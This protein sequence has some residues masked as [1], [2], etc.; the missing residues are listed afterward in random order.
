MLITHYH[1]DHIDGLRNKAGEFVFA[2]R[3]GHGAGARARLLDGRRAAWPPR[4]RP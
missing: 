1:G 2:K 4:P 3:Q